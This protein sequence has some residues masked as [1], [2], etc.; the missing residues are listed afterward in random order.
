M[1]GLYVD[2]NHCL[3][4]VLR[5]RDTAT[6]H[7]HAAD[8]EDDGWSAVAHEDGL[9]TMD[10]PRGDS[11]RGEYVAEKRRVVWQSGQVWDRVHVSCEQQ[12]LLLRRPYVPIT[13]VF[14]CSLW[15]IVCEVYGAVRRRLAR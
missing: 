10:L 1:E 4:V 11:D 2:R 12:A 7:V 15:Y 6:W 13:V 9:L 8:V 3:Y 14:F 5:G